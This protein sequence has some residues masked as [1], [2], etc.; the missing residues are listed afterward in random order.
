LIIDEIHKLQDGDL[1]ASEA[2]DFATIQQYIFNSYKQSGE[3]SVR[4]LLMTATPITDSPKGL[5][6]IVNTL[7]PVKEDQLLPFQEFREKFTDEKGIISEGGKDYFRS[8]AKGLISYLNREYDPTAF[9][10]PVFETVMVGETKVAKHV[11][12]VDELAEECIS[13]MPIDALIAE[14]IAEQDCDAQINQETNAI[15]GQIKELRA[16]IAVVH[17]DK[18]KTNEVKEAEIATI[19]TEVQRLT[20]AVAAVKDKYAVSSFKCKQFNKDLASK[21][22]RTRKSSTHGILGAMKQCYTLHKEEYDK[23]EDTSKQMTAIRA[24]LKKGKENK[25]N[26]KTRKNRAAADKLPYVDRYAFLQEVGHRLLP[27]EQSPVQVD[28][29][30]PKNR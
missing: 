8:R 18:A 16:Q 10:Q 7:I 22:K 13:N 11:P 15:K 19:Q 27:G 25:E 5:F 21:M 23:K 26:A 12:T 9:S 24:C 30:R 2:A 29:W 28:S 17:K 3:D 1:S 14:Q 20:A 4:P 6:D